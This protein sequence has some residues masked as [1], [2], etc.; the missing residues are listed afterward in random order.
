MRPLLDATFRL[1]RNALCWWVRVEQVAQPLDKTEL[2]TKL[3]VVYVLENRSLVDMMVLDNQAQQLGLP[4]ANKRLH[5]PGVEGERAVFFLTTEVS[6]FNRKKYGIAPRLKALIQYLE[7]NPEQDVQLVPVFLIWGRGPAR[8]K[9]FFKALLSDA[10]T[11]TG[12][13]KKLFTV[14]LNGRSTYVEFNKPISLRQLADED[15]SP[16]VTARKVNRVLRV[17]F[18]RIRTRVVGPDLS[19]RRL[20]LS[21]LLRT[22]VV[23]NATNTYAKSKKVSRAKANKVARQQAEEIAANVS[24]TTVRMLDVILTRLW[25]KIYDGIN[26]ANI[27]PVKEL[28][29]RAEIVYAPCH[30]SHIDYLLLSYC[31]YYQG[32]NIPHIAAGNNLNIPVVGGILRRGGAFFMRRSFRGDKLYAALF[33][34]YIHMVFT[35][36]HPMEYFVEGGRSRTGRM[37]QPKAG[38][39]NMTI[40]SYLRDHNRPIVVVPVYIGYEKVFEE[41]TYLN[42]LR[43]QKKEKESLGGLW[44]S[45]RRLKNFGK[46]SLNFGEPIHL[47]QLLNNI[48]PD[49]K[50]IDYGQEIKPSWLVSATDQ[51]SNLLAQRINGAAALNPVNLVATVMLATERHVLAEQTLKQQLALYQTLMS[52][53]PYSEKI[54]LPAGTPEDW[55]VGVEKTGNLVRHPESDL[56]HILSLE[57]DQAILL[58]Y[59]R[60]N[61]LHLFA[62]P[63]LIA[64]LFLDERHFRKG[65]ATTIIKGI[66]PFLQA[67]LFLQWSEQQLD[68]LVPQWLDTF[69]NIGLLNK[70][71]GN[72]FSVPDPNREN[73][74][75]LRL[76]AQCILPALERYHIT[77]SI[78]KHAGSGA[79]S[80]SELEKRSQ[81][82]AQYLSILSGMSAPE[83]FDRS[84][85]RQFIQLLR[86]K[87]LLSADQDNKL[88][89]NQSLLDL[90]AQITTLVSHSVSLEINQVVGQH[91][92]VPEV[93]KD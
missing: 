75:S 16:E 3:P 73:F 10:W 81:Q 11:A 82:I 48:Q 76:L 83:F 78:L 91:L 63:A 88:T 5:L 86:Q 54:T 90:L 65:E 46:V 50:E 21:R 55:I 7:Q 56:G 31:L 93:N 89:F 61:V 1:V 43:G 29:Q 53:Q 28:A 68:T 6:L 77:L 18:R 57:P 33:N 85:F 9:S 60:N 44:R 66:Y 62:M 12:R 36:G 26:V 22:P 52:E 23:K 74:Q 84:L 80:A 41:R 51:L 69:T 58:T 40:K 24:F 67:E 25:N 20:L 37:L 70:N 32:L 8:K 13:I 35:Q 34:E 15:D 38:M 79:F 39:L 17:H 19:H 64:S 4:A 30:R 71:K 87:E 2:N 92:V 45:F 49:W 27:E 14:L 42:E 59:Y 47:D 72:V